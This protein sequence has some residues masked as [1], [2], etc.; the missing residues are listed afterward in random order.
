MR[1]NIA[2]RYAEIESQLVAKFCDALRSSDV[3]R[4]KKFASTLQLFSHVS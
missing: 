4:M 3:K 2:Q 1:R